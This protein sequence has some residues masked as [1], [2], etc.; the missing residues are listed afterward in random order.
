MTAEQRYDALVDEVFRFYEQ[1]RLTGALDAIRTADADLAPWRAELAHTEACILGADHRPAEALHAL[2]TAFAEGAWWHRKIL[3]EDDDLEGLRD[4]PG[5]AD[6]VEQSD[7]RRAA[8]TD[9]P[10]E[11][12]L[13]RPDGEIGGV[14]V[15]LHGAGQRAGHAR[16]DWSSALD[17]GYAVLAVESAQRMSPM[18]RTWPDQELAA[19]DIAAAIATL[20]D[21][22]RSG[23]LIAAGFSAGARAALLWALTDKP[24]P[25]TGV[26]VLAP[27]IGGVDLPAGKTL[28]PAIAW[29]GSED[30]LLEHA[31]AIERLP[32]FTVKVIQGLG[33]A[34]PKGR[35]LTEVLG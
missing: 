22:I 16:R 33:H 32:G 30:D 11:H 7:Q 26:V 18:Y 28:N 5:F 8:E 12:L 15:A 19:K 13:D 14:L 17:R 9:V 20:P 4:L 27:A 23:P 35:Q 29:Y 34:F 1:G 2:Q 24:T 6:L 31:P 21:D 3:T 25:A 10:G